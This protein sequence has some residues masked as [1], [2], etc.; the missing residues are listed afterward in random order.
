[1]TRKHTH[2]HRAAIWSALA[3]SLASPLVRA[4]A[5]PKADVAVFTNHSGVHPGS[6]ARMALQVTLPE[7]VHVQ[8]NA[9]RDP[10][11]IA[12]AVTVTNPAGATL[13]EIVY[14]PASD[15]RQIGQ[16]TPLAVFEQRFAVGISVAVSVS[17]VPGDL[18]V[19]IRFRYQA[20]DATTC[21]APLRDELSG[22][23]HVVP[24]RVRVTE[25]NT[26]LFKGLRFRR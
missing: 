4:Q 8:S 3:L 21:F 14:P 13:E 19:P 6:T 5:R 18:I 17:A 23:L 12:T 7:G 20:C 26:A 16:T 24:A 11:L 2:V 15:F 25:Q 22:T 10:M 9:P 1:M